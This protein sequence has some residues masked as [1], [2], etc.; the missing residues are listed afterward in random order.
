MVDTVQ[1]SVKPSIIPSTISTVQMENI[2]KKSVADK[3]TCILPGII[4]TTLKELNVTKPIASN[5]VT[6][7]SITIST[8]TGEGITT[9]MSK[10]STAKDISDDNINIT[11]TS[12]QDS[13][14]DNSSDQADE[15]E[16][17]EEMS[18]PLQP[19]TN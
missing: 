7:T 17:I 12:S 11:A 4:A 8:I 19:P 9:T 1:T 16:E 5:I 15:T 10:E 6:S 18:A 13:M 3:S 2:I 14:S